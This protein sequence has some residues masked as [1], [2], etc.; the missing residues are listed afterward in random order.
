[1]TD[2]TSD[3]STRSARAAGAAAIAALPI[4]LAALLGFGAL[5]DGYAQTA[6]PIALLGADGG[7]RAMAFNLLAYVL[8]GA[9]AA[10]AAWRLRG[11]LALAG[12][13]A[14]IGAQLALLAAL[15]FIAQGLLPLDLEDVHGTANAGHAAA[16]SVWW[17][18][19]A[20]A[21]ALLAVAP[22]AP[23][24]VRTATAVAAAG[25]LILA[26]WPWDGAMTALAQ[27]CAVVLWLGWVAVV[28][29]TTTAS[30]T[31]GPR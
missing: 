30:P 31:A 4:F 7:A 11:A 2:H 5:Q 29:G 12:W 13:T 16:W 3:T 9:A 19:F 28:S 25:V 14:R 1:M 27:R 10:W 15:G 18:A 23:R 6:Q 22:A 8:P 21:G 26:A 20:L 17:L 24:R